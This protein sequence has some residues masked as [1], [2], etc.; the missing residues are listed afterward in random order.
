MTK[1]TMR[2]QSGS[3]GLTSRGGGLPMYAQLVTLFRQR[4]ESGEWALNDK[5]PSLDELCVE[6]DVARVTVR[7]ALGLLE[8]EG[9]IGRYRGRGTFVLHK[10]ESTIWYR[11]PNDL[12]SLVGITPDIEFEWLDNCLAEATPVPFHGRGVLAPAYQYLRRRLLRHHVPYCIG[13]TFIEKT[14]FDAIGTEGFGAPVP[15]AKLNEHLKGG[16]AHAEQTIRA[17]TAD[18]KTAQLLQLEP[19]AAVM[20]VMRTVLN[21]DDVL[22]YESHGTFRGDFVEVHTNLI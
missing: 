21:H 9:L 4:I 17:S 11:I 16:I 6:F 2:A 1:S 7:T 13:A 3:V 12:E 22:V 18:L 15:L 5:L 20:V 8:A 19:G 14:A 10:P